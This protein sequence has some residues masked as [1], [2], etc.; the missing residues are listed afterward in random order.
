[1]DFSAALNSAS[2]GESLIKRNFNIERR[3]FRIA[4]R[5]RLD[6]VGDQACILVE[7]K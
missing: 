1:M 5:Y 2:S 4:I 6:E 7:R 3:E